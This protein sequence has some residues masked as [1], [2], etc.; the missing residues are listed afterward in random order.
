MRR[1]APSVL[2]ADF[3]CLA[4]EVAQVA[5]TGILHLDVMDG[6]FVPNISFGPPVIRSL[7]THTDAYFDT[8]LMIEAPGRYVEAFAAAGADRLSVHPEACEDTRA[9]ID[10]IHAEGLD[11]GVVLNPG[12]DI[13]A[14]AALFDA[15]EVVLLMGVE[16][17]FGGQ[18]FIDATV[19][20]VAAVADRTDTEVAV[21]GGIDAETG[22]R[23]AAAGANTFVIGSSLFGADDVPAALARLE[24][25]IGVPE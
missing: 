5:D 23:C 10:A 11:A 13:E 21:D 6:Q 19:D 2:A 24:D 12:T 25:A 20:R 8:H 3:G 7:G 9:T 4:D 1:I 15:V 14:T 22:P 17:G 16:P 18:S